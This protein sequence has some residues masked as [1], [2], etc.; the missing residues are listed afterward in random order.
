MD[1]T[2]PLSAFH[3]L[4]VPVWLPNET[5][6]VARGDRIVSNRIGKITRTMVSFRFGPSRKSKRNVCFRTDQDRKATHFSSTHPSLLS[7]E[8]STDECVEGCVE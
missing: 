4:P 5:K 2:I 3:V 1:S 6:H 8:P 7:V